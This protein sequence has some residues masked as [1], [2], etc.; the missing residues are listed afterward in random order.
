MACDKRDHS[1]TCPLIQVQKVSKVYSNSERTPVLA[2][3]AITLDVY[4]GELVSV[5]GPSGCGKTT[6]LALI[7]GLIK[8]TQGDICVNKQPVRCPGPDRTLIFQEH[9]LFPW[10]TVI[11]NVEF[12]LKARGM[13]REQRLSLARR[14]IDLVQL[15]GFEDKLPHQ[16]SGGMRQRVAIAR[17]L[18]LQPI[19]I[20]MDEPFGALDAQLRSALQEELLRILAEE[21]LAIVFVTHDVEEALYLSDR[22]VILSKRPG[23][24]RK[25]VE[26]RLPKPRTVYT[27]LSAEFQDLKSLVFAQFQEDLTPASPA[28]V[29]EPRS[30]R[31]PFAGGVSIQAKFPE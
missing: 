9:N 18:V 8:C 5:I 26:P 19:C 14:Y 30:H 31:L 16:L 24:V 6:L 1:T 17:A 20:L 2:L 10:K 29:G 28:A 13:K 15:G 4:P 22:I 27:K 23:Q 25:I 12:G 3:D 11:E 21:K 7:A